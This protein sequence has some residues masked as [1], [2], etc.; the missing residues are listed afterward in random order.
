MVVTEA[1]PLE[2]IAPDTKITF[3]NYKNFS[4]LMVYMFIK[5]RIYVGNTPHEFN[6]IYK[7]FRREMCKSK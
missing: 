6:L 4:L 5:D 1:S 3:L 7:S 2:V